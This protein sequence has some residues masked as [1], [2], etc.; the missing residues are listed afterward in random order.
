M[1]PIR[2]TRHLSGTSVFVRAVSRFRW[3]EKLVLVRGFV[4][5]ARRM[6]RL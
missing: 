5:G 2:A 1:T 3:H 4:I 6:Q